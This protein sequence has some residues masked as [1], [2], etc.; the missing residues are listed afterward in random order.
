M[1]VFGSAVAAP[2]RDQVERRA[3][4][5][6]AA[7][8]AIAVALAVGTFLGS[9]GLALAAYAAGLLAVERSAFPAD[10]RLVAASIFRPRRAA[11]SDAAG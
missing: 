6:F 1:S 4:A 11:K 5:P 3:A 10:L 2:V 8:A 9:L 7:A